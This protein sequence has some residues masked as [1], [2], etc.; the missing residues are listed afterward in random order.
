VRSDN[1]PGFIAKEIQRW[2]Q[3][4]SVGTLYI[5]KASPWGNGYVESFSGKLRGDC[6]NGE[7]FLSPTEARYVVDRWRLDYNHHRPR[8]RLAWIRPAAFAVAC[9]AQGTASPRPPQH[10]PEDVGTTRTQ[11]GT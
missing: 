9:A 4:A 11:V 10:T 7:L 2:L 3:K 5:Q 8:S 1:G 6:L